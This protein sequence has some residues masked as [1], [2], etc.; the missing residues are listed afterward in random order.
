MKKHVLVLAIAAAMLAACGLV[1]CGGGGG[2]AVL[3]QAQSISLEAPLSSI[4]L[5]STMV[6]ASASSGLPVSYSST[7]PSVCDVNTR[8]GEVSG[9]SVGTCTLRVTQRGDTRYAP[10]PPLE[11]TL[12]VSTNPAQTLS[13]SAARS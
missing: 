1:A 6:T 4:G 2:D 10:A 13:F 12:T 3:A 7:T 8:T 9:L 11:L 5:G